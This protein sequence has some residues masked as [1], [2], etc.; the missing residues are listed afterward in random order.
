M[1]AR[2]IIGGAGEDSPRVWAFSSE[3]RNL[4]PLRCPWIHPDPREGWRFVWGALWRVKA[5]LGVRHPCRPGR[6]KALGEALVPGLTL[7]QALAI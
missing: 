5:L 2:E 6:D 3:G 7:S 1:P 4:L